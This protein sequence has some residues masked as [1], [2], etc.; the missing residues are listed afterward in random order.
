MKETQQA[1]LSSRNAKREREQEMRRRETTFARCIFQVLVK[2]KVIL[3]FSVLIGR[4]RRRLIQ[5]VPVPSLTGF[6]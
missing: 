2:N 4:Q 5:K 3:R 6:A 1:A